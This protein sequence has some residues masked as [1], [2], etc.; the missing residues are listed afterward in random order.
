MPSKMTIMGILWSV[1]AVAVVARVEPARRL[2]F[3]Q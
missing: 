1:A 3:N 2:V